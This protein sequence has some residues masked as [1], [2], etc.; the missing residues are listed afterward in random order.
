MAHHESG[1]KRLGAEAGLIPHTGL[2][3]ALSLLGLTFGTLWA[4]VCNPVFAAKLLVLAAF[5][6]WL[7][8]SDG[9]MPTA[10][11]WIMLLVGATL[12]D[13]IKTMRLT[14]KRNVR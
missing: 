3:T 9:H 14:R 10:L 8:P 12:A 11:Y 4:C 13:D 7:I 2:L 6:A 5:F 1:G